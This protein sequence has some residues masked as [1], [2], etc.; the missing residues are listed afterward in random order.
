[1]F[2]TFLSLKSLSIAAAAGS[3]LVF[4][5]IAGC[6]GTSSTSGSGSGPGITGT[7]SVLSQLTTKTTI[8][9][10]VDPTNG[11]K[12]PTGLAIAPATAGLI[13][14]GDLIVCN[15]SNNN[16]T[17]PPAGGTTIEDLAPT[18]NSTPK[19][20]AQNS[21]LVG[22][23]SL[24]L[25]STDSIWV[26]ASPAP[27]IAIVSPTGTVSTTLTSSFNW[28]SPKGLTFAVPSISSGIKANPTFYVSQAGNVGSI[29]AVE[30]TNSG[31]VFKT[32]VTGFPESLISLLS[33]NGPTY[34]ANTDTLYIVSMDTNSVVAIS[35]VSTV[36]ANGI[37]VSSSGSGTLSFSG[38]AAAQ[39]RV[40]Y[41][42][43][44][45]NAPVSAA[46]L[47]NGDL[48]VDNSDDNNLVEIDPAKGAVIGTTLV[49]SGKA[50]A[51]SGI[52]TEGATL[53][54]QKVFFNDDNTNTVVEL[55]Q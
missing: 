38:P 14:A 12:D 20:I 47:Y 5:L 44:S 48:I 52:A 55:S 27:G 50:P 40:V 19:R 49:D 41:S 3:L 24:A 10:T 26:T 15:Y 4:S 32:I 17:G 28:Q 21:S 23:T 2:R 29:V 30:I 7:P 31:P 51:I 37:T 42:G 39:A 25:D 8:G 16:T 45:L 36:P 43:S 46:M 53:A 9:S 6:S 35:K 34:D 54:T 33:P 22:C 18:A 1:M 13:T 11:D